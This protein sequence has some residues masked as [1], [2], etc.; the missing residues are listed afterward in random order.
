MESYFSYQI[1]NPAEFQDSVLGW[2]SSVE[3]D[4]LEETDNGWM[5]YLP[6]SKSS[7][8]EEGVLAELQ[9]RFQ[10]TFDRQ[11]VPN[12]NWNQEWESN[13]KPVLVGS[14]CHINRHN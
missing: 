14:F 9:Q 7:A 6:A 8:F 5:V 12:I 13:F 11:E 4:M 2:L 10:V 3:L 1:K